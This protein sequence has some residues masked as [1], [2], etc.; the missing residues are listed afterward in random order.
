MSGGHFNHIQSKIENFYDELNKEVL[1]LEN[2][3][4]RLN[5]DGFNYNKGTIKRIKDFLPLLKLT[6]KISREIDYLFEG[7]HSEKSF[8]ELY[9]QHVK[10]F[11]PYTLNNN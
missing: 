7:D 2:S 3:K 4:D 10:D 8:Q 11:L 9:D 6:Y 1:E 5:E